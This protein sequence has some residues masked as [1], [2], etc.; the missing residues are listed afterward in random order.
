MGQRGKQR[1]ARCSNTTPETEPNRTSEPRSRTHQQPIN[2]MASEGADQKQELKRLGFL[3]DYAAVATD[4]S[5]KYY[6]LV[7]KQ[8][9]TTL[10]PGIETLEGAIKSYG[11]PIVSKV[12]DI[13]P[14]VVSE[15]DKRV[16]GIVGRANG[17]YENV[18]K[19]TSSENIKVFK[20][21]RE[22]YLKQIETLLE[23][24]KTKGFQ[25][26][27]T[28][29][30]ALINGMKDTVVKEG[31]K[32]VDSAKSTPLYAKTYNTSVEYLTKAQDRHLQARHLP[33]R[34][35]QVQ[36][37][38]PRDQGH[39]HRHP[40]RREGRALRGDHTPEPQARLHLKRHRTSERERERG[41]ERRRD[42][43][44]ENR[45]TDGKI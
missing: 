11:A 40:V 20:K 27:M 24:L 13:G 16:D 31:I 30:M 33:P 29:V 25:G 23:E 44:L 37:L 14:K 32:R 9:P 19:Y 26:S 2:A 3:Y 8:A 18:T 12:Q 36:G 34:G 6:E 5:A 21:T 45:P 41:G 1:L 17:V 7:K 43:D 35:R 28:D 38:P 42:Q 39:H 15:A 4:L 10:S 22:E